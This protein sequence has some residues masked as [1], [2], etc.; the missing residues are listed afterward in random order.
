MRKIPGGKTVE[1]P[2]PDAGPD[3]AMAESMR[4]Q[5]LQARRD[6]FAGHALQGL[7]IRAGSGEQLGDIAAR[8]FQLADLMITAAEVDR[9]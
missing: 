9:G 5:V 6:F 3:E 8:A 1:S 7:I 4:R 2:T